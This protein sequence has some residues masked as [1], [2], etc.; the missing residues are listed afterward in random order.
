MTSPAAPDIRRAL[1]EDAAAVRDLTRAAYAKWV[2]VIGREPKPMLADY[3]R[4]VR[5]HRIGLLTLDGALAALVETVD[6]GDHLLIE[7]LAVAPPF[8]GRGLGRRLLGHA[9]DLA[10]ALGHTELRL[11]TNKRM[12]ANI[13][14]YQRT[15]YRI[16]R[17]VAFMNGFTIHMS[18]RL[19]VENAG[20]S[21]AS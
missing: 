12:A 10:R 2:P 11:Y 5:E 16:D 9:E 7:N 14:L 4:A 6:K 8:Q 18:K 3:D 21:D 1:P 15:G 20:G 19:Q 17:E 13:A